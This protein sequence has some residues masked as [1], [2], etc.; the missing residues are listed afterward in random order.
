MVHKAVQRWRLPAS[1][2][3]WTHCP[4]AAHIHQE[5]SLPGVGL[6]LG[7]NAN[8]DQYLHGSPTSAS[9]GN[10]ISVQANR[11][12]LRRKPVGTIELVC[13]RQSCGGWRAYLTSR[14]VSAGW[15][16]GATLRPLP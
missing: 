15:L 6:A 14:R 3:A 11:H 4:A 9:C 7:G 8:A 16:S 12:V 10:E 5:L 2:P 1:S 13:A